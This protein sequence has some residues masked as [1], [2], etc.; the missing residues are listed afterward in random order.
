[1][2][3]ALLTSAGMF[4][5]CGGKQTSSSN[6]S[7]SGAATSSSA[8]AK[9]TYPINT[10]KTLSYWCIL[11]ATAAKNSADLGQ[12]PLYKEMQAKTGVKLKFIT[13]TAN[14]SK[15]TLNLMIASNDLPDIIEYNWLNSFPGGPEK[16]IK[17]GV[18]LPLNDLM[19]KNAPNFKNLVTTNKNIDKMVKTDGGKYYSF[20]FLR[21]DPSVSV[22]IGP[23]LRKDW[24]DELSLKTPE[25]IDEWYTVLKAFKDKKGVDSSFTLPTGSPNV[26]LNIIKLTGAFIGAYGIAYDFY[27]QD[28]KVVY[29][30][31]QPT[32]KDFL[33]MMNKWYK[34]G[35]I[36]KDLGIT[37]RKGGDAKIL[38]GKTGGIVGYC[39]SD[40][41]KYLD[42]M[43]TKDPK[44]NLVGVP[45]PTLKKGDKPEFGHLSNNLSGDGC[46]AITT[47]S[48][49]KELAAQ[50][51]DYA[52]GTEG[53]TLMNFGIQDVSYKME[54]GYPKYTDIIFKNP[55]GLT[56]S[57]ALGGY[58][59]A[60]YNGP[61]VQDP[62]YMEQYYQYPQQKD[63]IKA[64]ANT[65]ESKHLLPPI[66][67]TPEESSEL[68][69]I[70][71]NVETYREEMVMKFILGQEPLDKFDA[72]LAQMKKLNIDRAVELKQASLDR[73]NKR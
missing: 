54:N 20:P 49:N 5:G 16:A 30:P 66:T 61:F 58:T 38:A 33:T 69:T 28:G 18:I 25:T 59:R 15:E 11:D 43:K 68:A 42:S 8:P 65:N 64:W 62:K 1:M 17:D 23:M 22:F 41:S 63:A 13:T 50:F 45:Y 37:D 51:L 19:D 27:L 44:F 2:C 10:D 32:F 3:L 73:Y 31:T 7:A 35:L 12:I 56:V 67:A 4:A 36:D 71:N 55:N 34:E 72:Y 21:M 39:G 46:A 9:I 52:Y 40:M 26:S 57:E 53:N 14:N 24:L 48:K 60:A 47:A 6:P 70:L 29:G